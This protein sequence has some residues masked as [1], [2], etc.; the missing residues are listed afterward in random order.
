MGRERGETG[1]KQSGGRE[2]R[3]SAGP[4]RPSGWSTLA[5]CS[6]VVLKI[7]C[8]SENPNGNKY[9]CYMCVAWFAPTSFS[10]TTVLVSA[11][12]NCCLTMSSQPDPQVLQIYLWSVFGNRS[13]GKKLEWDKIRRGGFPW[14]CQ[15]LCGKRK[16][17]LSWHAFCSSVMPSPAMRQEEGPQ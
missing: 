14:W 2:L 5:E 4:P 10:H 9:A 7:M 8:K 3:D 15:W 1:A 11:P 6:Q 13:L 16:K 17:P 12:G